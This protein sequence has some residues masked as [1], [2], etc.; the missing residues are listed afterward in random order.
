M[1]VAITIAV[2]LAVMAFFALYLRRLRL[3]W[4]FWSEEN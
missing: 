2:I 3:N 1:L 4:E